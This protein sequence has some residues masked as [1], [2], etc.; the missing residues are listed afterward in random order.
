M[1]KQIKSETLDKIKARA[2]QKVDKNWDVEYAAKVQR[3]K[4]KMKTFHIESLSE[5]KLPETSRGKARARAIQ[6]QMLKSNRAKFHHTGLNYQNQLAGQM[7]NIGWTNSHQMIQQHRIAPN[8]LHQQYNLYNQYFAPTQTVNQHNPYNQYKTFPTQL[9]QNNFSASENMNLQSNGHMLKFPINSFGHRYHHAPIGANKMM[10][11]VANVAEFSPH[12]LIST[13]NLPKLSGSGI[14]RRIHE[15]NGK[16]GINPQQE[17]TEHVEQPMEIHPNDWTNNHEMMGIA[18][19]QPYQHYA[20][21]QTGFELPSVGDAI[22]HPDGQ[23]IAQFSTQPLGH[24]YHQIDEPYQIISPVSHDGSIS[25]I[26][27]SH[28]TISSLDSPPSSASGYIE[29]TRYDKHT[30]EHFPNHASSYHSGTNSFSPAIENWDWDQFNDLSP[31]EDF[32]RY[33][34]GDL[35]ENNENDGELKRLAHQIQHQSH[36]Q[37]K[38]GDKIVAVDAH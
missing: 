31:N 30:A 12:S 15:L 9:T 35:S 29:P 20:S 11:P 8:Q 27:G 32:H 37:L 1:S 3:N 14:F 4:D 19:I 21:P 16:T 33:E 24:T 5:K 23:H 25:P 26:S 38:T 36:G 2:Y 28:S 18:Q 7:H 10:E 22:I 6:R 17:Q 34:Y 13:P